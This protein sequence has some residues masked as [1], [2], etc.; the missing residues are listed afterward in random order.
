MGISKGAH[1][2]SYEIDVGRKTGFLGFGGNGIEGENDFLG[3][4]DVLI[5]ENL[6]FQEERVSSL[7]KWNHYEKWCAPLE[8]PIIYSI[9]PIVNLKLMPHLSP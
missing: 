9:S 2:F 3:V 5:S 6:I 4:R 7:E 1:K 8:T